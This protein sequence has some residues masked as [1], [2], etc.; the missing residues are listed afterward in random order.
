VDKPNYTN[1]VKS[2]LETNT[3]LHIQKEKGNWLKIQE[4]NTRIYINASKQYSSESGISYG[5][6]DLSEN[7]YDDFL[8]DNSN[9]CFNLILLGDTNTIFLIPRSVFIKIFDKKFMT[10]PKEWMFNILKED[11]KYILKF[12]NDLNQSDITNYLNKLDLIKNEIVNKAI[13]NNYPLDIE[14]KKEHINSIVQEPSIFLTGYNDKNLEISKRL[15]ILGWKERPHKLSSG[16]LVFVFNTT[17]KKIETCFEIKSESNNKNIIWYDEIESN[18]K[19]PLYTYR[20]NSEIKYDYINITLNEI[21][22][23]EPFKSNKKLFPLLIRNRFPRSINDSKYDSFRNFLLDRCTNNN[24]KKYLLLLQQPDSKWQD[25]EGSKYNFG[26]NVPNYNIVIPGAKAVFFSYINNKMLFFGHGSI[27]SIEEIGLDGNTPSGRPILK[28]VAKLQNYTRVN[29]PELKSVLIEEKVRKLPNFNKQHS[30]REIP[31]DI[32]DM[33]VKEQSLEP[34]NTTINDIMI[35]NIN[36]LTKW[37]ELDEHIINDIVNETLHSKKYEY[38]LEI[39]EEIIKNIIN[40]LICR[41]HVILIG[42]P[43]TGKTDLAKRLLIELGERKLIRNKEPVVAVASYEWGR[44]EVIGGNSLQMD[45]KSNKYIFHFGCVTKAIKEEKFLL[46]DEFNRADMNKAFGEMFLAVD[47]DRI[48]LRENEEPY[49]IKIENSAI[50]IPSEF[51]IICTMNDYDKSLLNELSYG[52]LRRFAFVEIELPH[53]DK[54]IKI[55]EDRIKHRLKIDNLSL[56]KDLFDDLNSQ[57]EESQF[58]KKE[59][60]ILTRFIEFIYS[61]KDKRTIGV[62]TILDI[63]AYLVSG[64]MFLKRGKSIDEKWKLLDEALVSYIIPQLDRLDVDVL[65][66]VLEKSEKY[67][68]VLN[69]ENKKLLTEKFEMKIKNMHENLEK[70]NELFYSTK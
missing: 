2:Y 9:E 5:W 63:I 1:L 51:R 36:N 49:G 55:I 33:I 43:G 32:Y 24:N 3:N 17:S 38:P 44:Y 35:S 62:S 27:S 64:I 60:K 61:I 54:L 41:K 39:E 48:E 56:V 59:N 67:F 65:T 70:L 31:K 26:N 12:T 29:I 16:D 8:N 69:Q 68:Q 30:I 34:I 15:K 57:E 52:L 66:S 21:S 13:S 25:E 23:F 58:L 53:K 11:G 20:W 47:H 46:I 10:K 40:H 14:P 28:K 4:T 37:S 50:Q 19:R 6:Y 7:T 42:P 18:S 22:N 45:V